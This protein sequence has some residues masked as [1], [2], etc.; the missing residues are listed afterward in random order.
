MPILT[1]GGEG[2]VGDALYKAV[3]TK[4]DHVEGDVM[5]GVGHYIPEEAP[6]RLVE[7]LLSFA[8]S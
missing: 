6:E 1:L 3:K 8:S 5:A 7:R 2:A 4:V